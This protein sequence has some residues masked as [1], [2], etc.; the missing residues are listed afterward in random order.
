MRVLHMKFK[1]YVIVL[2]LGIIIV[3]FIGDN[4]LVAHLRNKQ[5]INELKA[6]I[7]YNIAV[8][9]HNQ[10]QVHL[11][12]TDPKTVERVGRMRYFMK[13][14]DEDVFILSDDNTADDILEDD[15]TIE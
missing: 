3:G 4:S 8:T 9:K 10:E 15:E 11:L 2:A 1:K 13:R 12:Q 14:A 6:E 7:N 5:H